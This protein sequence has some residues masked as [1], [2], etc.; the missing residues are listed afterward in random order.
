MIHVVLV[1]R[2]ARKDHGERRPGLSLGSQRVSVEVL[3]Y[4]STRIMA[5]SRVRPAERSNN[6]SFSS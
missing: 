1:I 4:A 2:L 3:L 6:S 5:P